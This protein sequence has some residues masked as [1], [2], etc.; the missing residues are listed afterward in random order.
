MEFTVTTTEA[1]KLRRTWL[2]TQWRQNG[3]ARKGKGGSPQ[4][5]RISVN[6]YG[7]SELSSG[8]NEERAAMLFKLINSHLKLEKNI[9]GVPNTNITPD[10]KLF[11][12]QGDKFWKHWFKN[13]P[14]T[15]DN[16]KPHNIRKF[17]EF[18]EPIVLGHSIQRLCQGFTC[19]LENYEIFKSMGFD[20]HAPTKDGRNVRHRYFAGGVCFHHLL[21]KVTK[22]HKP[23]ANK[24]GEVEPY[25][26]A[27][28]INLFYVNS[29]HLNMF[30]R[31][32]TR[33]GGFDVTPDLDVFPPAWLKA[34]EEMVLGRL[35]NRS[36]GPGKF[37]AT[38]PGSRKDP[39]KGKSSKTKASKPRTSKAKKEVS[40]RTHDR[41]FTV[42]QLRDM[43]KSNDLKVSGR[44]DELIVR[45]DKAGKL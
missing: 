4:G 31:P 34:R 40:F 41:S 13:L 8:M 39:K 37:R 16:D 26:G 45:L 32:Y 14:Q 24:D 27:L 11:Y 43:C 22:H 42:R 29:D 10:S 23:R 18:D 3:P 5:D 6:R 25:Q 7:F 36:K 12:T 15:L 9:D 33:K 28:S 17:M 2:A 1:D 38:N 44:K 19:D 30:I 20:V 35:P 21:A